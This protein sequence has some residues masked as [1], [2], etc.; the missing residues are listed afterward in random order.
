MKKFLSILA[1]LIISL[2]LF[3]TKPV[4]LD[5]QARASKGTKINLFWVLPENPDQEITKLLIYRSTTPITRYSQ[6]KNLTPIAE[7]SGTE[8]G[9]TDSVKDYKDY[10]YAVITVTDK[11][12]EIIL[13]SMN[14][15]VNGVHLKLQTKQPQAPKKQ[16]EEKQKLADG[17]LAAKETA[18]R[19]I[20]EAEEKAAAIIA[21]AEK[22]KE[23][24]LAD[25]K[26]AKTEV[27]DFR[28]QIRDVL[29][30]M[31]EGLKH[32]EE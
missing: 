30:T 32:C 10:F 24:I 31:D 22:E 14:S 18:D 6:I 23:K 4:I 21:D 17:I 28:R 15:T 19:L 2:P 11:P 20:A 5:I 27:S 29:R 12:S 9:Y 3:A 25:A 26:S 16:E 13:A 1:L 7:L 8:T